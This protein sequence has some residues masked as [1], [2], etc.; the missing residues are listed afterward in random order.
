M[1]CYLSQFKED[2]DQPSAQDANPVTHYRQIDRTGIWTPVFS[3]R[4]PIL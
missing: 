2:I 3:L 1:N 4:K